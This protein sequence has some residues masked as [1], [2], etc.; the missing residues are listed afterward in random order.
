[1]VEVELNRVALKWTELCRELF[2]QVLQGQGSNH[3]TF[4]RS[5]HSDF[6]VAML[7]LTISLGYAG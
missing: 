7:P 3:Q 1:M 5:K 6:W 4:P 2:G